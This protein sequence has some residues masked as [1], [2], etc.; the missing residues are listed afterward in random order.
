[1]TASQS[2]SMSVPTADGGSVTVSGSITA[3]YNPGPPPPVPPSPTIVGLDDPTPDAGL[4]PYVGAQRLFAGNALPDCTKL[5]AGVLAMPSMPM[6]ATARPTAAAFA[7]M[8]ASRSGG[9]FIPNHE[10]NRP[11][12]PSPSEVLDNMA[13]CRQQI[14]AHGNPNWLLAINFDCYPQTHPDATHR[15][16]DQF[17]AAIQYADLVTWD[18]YVDLSLAKLPSLDVFM[19]PTYRATRKAYP[20]KRGGVLELGIMARASGTPLVRTPQ[21]HQDAA[22]MYGDVVDE[23]TDDGGFVVCAWGT[24]GEQVDKVTGKTIDYSLAPGSP[25]YVVVRDRMRTQ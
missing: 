24:T 3:A 7:A 18:L 13:W 12:K 20:G 11:G 9:V 4:A 19:G 17:D 23:V 25:E 8:L 6:R 21:S 22:D 2:I 5:D 1:M 14:D 15:T 16:F 10:C